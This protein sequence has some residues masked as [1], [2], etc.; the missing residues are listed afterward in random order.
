MHYVAHFG[1]WELSVFL[2]RLSSP[3]GILRIR[4]NNGDLRN[5]HI[6]VLWLLW[7][8]GSFQRGLCHSWHG[9]IDKHLFVFYLLTCEDMGIREPS[10]VLCHV[11]QNVMEINWNSLQVV[12]WLV[13]ASRE[14]VHLHLS[15]LLWQIRI[16][17]RNH[18]RTFIDEFE[19]P[20]VTIININLDLSL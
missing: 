3:S 6:F 1:F 13:S 17:S 9:F 2:S 18:K 12:K 4:Y 19:F 7:H 16:S 8:T 11:C 15:R 5:W 10:G 20:P 14:I